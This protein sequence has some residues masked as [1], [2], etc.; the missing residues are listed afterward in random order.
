MVSGLAIA[1]RIKAAS[2]IWDVHVV[3]SRSLR[4]ISSNLIGPTG[5]IRQ[6]SAVKQR[7]HLSLGCWRE[8]GFS[9]IGDDFVAISTPGK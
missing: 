8:T 7:L 5:N 6:V 1:G 3:P 4:S 2:L 9:Y